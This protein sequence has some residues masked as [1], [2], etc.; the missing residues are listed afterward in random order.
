MVVIKKIS[1]WILYTIALILVLAVVLI[2]IV[3]FVIYPNIDKYKVDIA[4]QAAK[5]LNQKVTIGSIHT[6]WDGISPHFVI[7]NI[8]IFDA[9]NRPSLHL[10]DAEATVSWTSLPLMQPRLSQLLV[11]KPELT[12]RRQAD[13]TIFI[14][15]ISLAGEGNPDFANWLLSQP[16]V[17]V[18]DANIIWLDE[19][20][21]APALSLNNLNVTL[22]NPAWRTLFGQHLFTLSASPSVGTTH[23]IEANGSFY[24]RDVSKINTWHGKAY[25]QAEE[26]DLNAWG[27]WLDYPFE[28]KSGTGN[29]KVW[30][31]FADSRINHVKAYVALNKLTTILN[32]SAEPFVADYFSG[33]ITWDISNQASVFTAKDIKLKASGGLNVDGAS[34]HI[35][36]TTKNNKPWLEA[37]INLNQ[38]NLASIK[39][40]QAFAPV[41]QAYTEKLAAFS[42]R[43]E[44]K[45]VELSWQGEWSEK[46]QTTARYRIKAQFK[47]L[48]INAHEKIPGFEN[49]S[50]QINADQDNGSLDLA[51]TNAS[52]DLKDILRWPIPA[53]ELKGKVSWKINNNKAKIIANDLYITSSHITGT[54]NA[55]FDMS[56]AKGGYLDLI[57]KFSKGNAKYAPFYYPIILGTPTL[58]W[59]DTSILGGKAEDVL[60]TVKGN[61][62]DFPYV[63]KQNKL[64]PKLGIFKVTAKISDALLEY[65]TGWP[66]VEGLALDMLFEG[67]R[68]ELNAYKGHIFSNKIIK[69]KT[70][71]PQLD[72]D[73]PMLLITSEVEGTV[74]DGI[75]FVN[76]SPVKE[77]TLGFTDGLKTAGKGKLH[78]ELKIPMQDLEAAKYKGIYKITDGTIYANAEVGLPELSK[79]NGTLS[80]TEK[81]LNAQNVSTEILGGPAQFSLNTGSDK[82]IRINASGRINDAGIK[83]VVSNALTGALQGSTDWTG[84]ITIKKPLVD[85]NI[86]SNLIGMA[87]QLPAPLGKSASQQKQLEIDKKQL[88]A[89]EDTMDISY[90]RIVAA[91]ILRNDRSGSLAFDRGDIAINRA[92][93]QPSEPGLAIRGKLDHIDADE[94]LAIFNK[95]DSKSDNVPF[96]I[97]KA[98]FSVQ[99]L[100]IFNR[101]LNALRVIAKPSNTG[102]QMAIESQEITGNA[103]WQSAKQGAVDG[104]II[105]RLKNL[106]I[107]SNAAPTSSVAKK[108][109]KKLDSKYPA[110]DVSAESFQ[111]GNKSLGALELNAFESN[112]DWV[113]QKLKI[114]NPDYTLAADG[115]WHNWTRNPN[116]NFKFTL[117][118]DNVGKTLKRF[119]QPDMVK[120]GAAEISGQLRWPGSPHEF[121]TNGLDGNFKLEATKGQILKAQPGVGRLL[122]LLSLQ[123]LPRRLSLDFRDLFSEGFAF[124][125]ISATAKIDNGIMR[126][127]DFF[128]TGP[129]AEAKIKGETNL[130]K[131]TQNLRI[132]VIP[133][134]SDSLSLAALAGGPIAGA[135]A[136]V[137]QKILKD[138]FNKIIQSEYIVT[139]TWDN[140]QEVS[141]EKDDGKQLNSSSPLTP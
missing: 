59:L 139:G 134:I 24:G 103:E 85:L 75:R 83:K 50:G 96:T 113:I 33:L 86:R 19:L 100:E 78:L 106:T 127:N 27:P 140:P 95:P 16:K 125:K 105:A 79:I 128:M 77:V 42:P 131:E 74:V 101:K 40:L 73:W 118:A 61:L 15:G 36:Q 110:L 35:K 132:K 121:E 57:G 65:G 66:L 94:W 32:K 10:N 55:S 5:S 82:V 25:L 7:K 107:P 68:M 99:K 136:F 84:N 6:G 91:K 53:K 64:D 56:G 17:S 30:L 39:Q 28:L 8:D 67:K 137:A 124:D 49:L 37:A 23:P 52:L 119:G 47:G 43:G 109:I 138:P 120:D 117:K 93:E 41:P 45:D 11:R 135:A 51:S 90:D 3:R 104:K 29:T 97:S 89:H 81:S 133:H 48:G 87:V 14:A 111:I 18:K 80:F 12:I 13:G 58:H 38:F 31:E 129:A 34:G 60:L 116:T 108:D 88:N 20:R 122:G 21:K 114:T 141:A 115:S 102:L 9:E 1:R 22:K 54:V 4:A 130:Q 92:V 69:S 76:E 72:A 71:I 70:E 44:L 126:S 2:A 112:E 98:D 123:S 26:T 63:T 62:A 46:I